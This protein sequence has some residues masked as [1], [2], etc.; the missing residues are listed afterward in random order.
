MTTK[1]QEDSDQA[2][3]QLKEDPGKEGTI[4]LVGKI[5]LISSDSPGHSNHAGDIP[6]PDTDRRGARCSSWKWRW[7]RE[8][9]PTNSRQ[10]V[11]T[12][13]RPAS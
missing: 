9:W 3:T 1:E 10:P 2:M 8:H 13:S 5:R 7:I 4:E 11:A 12:S 6:V